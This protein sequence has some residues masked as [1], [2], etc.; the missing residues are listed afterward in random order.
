MKAVII[1]AEGH[2]DEE[3]CAALYCLQMAGV[4]VS[5]ATLD[6]KDKIGKFGVPARATMT[7]AQL[8]TA[9]FD[10]VVLPGGF[11][12]PDRVRL[13]PEVL[14]FV[15]EMGHQGKLVAAIC[16][17]GSILISAGIVRGRNVTAY[18]S[19]ADDLIN[20]GAIYHHQVPVIVDGNLITSPHYKWN[21]DFMRAVCKYLEDKEREDAVKRSYAVAP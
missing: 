9:N 3:Y 18:W 13:I 11:E 7:T 6:G 2:Q 4:E 5:V 15:A 8:D 10:A 12:A 1:T 20:A 14:N 19:I 16:H 17:A 21:G